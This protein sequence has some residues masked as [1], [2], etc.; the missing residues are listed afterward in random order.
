MYVKGKVVVRQ[1]FYLLSVNLFAE[2]REFRT[3]EYLLLVDFWLK[4]ECLKVSV[5]F[6]RSASVVSIELIFHLPAG[7]G[8][9]SSLYIHQYLSRS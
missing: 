7:F 1:I 6:F 8:F 5:N 9:S 4:Y 2:G 3:W